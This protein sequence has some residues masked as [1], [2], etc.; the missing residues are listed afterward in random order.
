MSQDK[1]YTNIVERER[2]EGKKKGREE[3]KRGQ[4]GTGNIL[5]RKECFAEKYCQEK[6]Y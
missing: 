4:A 3:R 5:S 6:R 1:I 2:E